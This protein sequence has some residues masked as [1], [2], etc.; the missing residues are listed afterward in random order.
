MDDVAAASGSR[1]LLIS[2]LDFNSPHVRPAFSRFQDV[3]ALTFKDRCEED[4]GF[5]DHWP[6]EP[7]DHFNFGLLRMANERVFSLTDAV[8]VV[9]FVE[10]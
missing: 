5:D 9:D 7:S 10:R 6:D 4:Y 3:L 2:I 8:R 1:N